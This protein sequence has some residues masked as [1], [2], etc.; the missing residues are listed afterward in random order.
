MGLASYSYPIRQP[1]AV[2]FGARVALA[3]RWFDLQLARGDREE[4]IRFE[5][6]FRWIARW[7]VRCF[8]ERFADATAAG[9]VL[10]SE[11]FRRSKQAALMMPADW[12]FYLRWTEWCRNRAIALAA[13]TGFP[14]RARNLE[15]AAFTNARTHSPSLPLISA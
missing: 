10:L 7:V 11:A 4:T 5:A 1:A 14:W 12:Q 3:A 2:M 9:L 6:G 15:M 13:L 8:A